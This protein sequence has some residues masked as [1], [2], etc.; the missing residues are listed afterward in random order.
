MKWIIPIGLLGA[1]VFISACGGS[2]N[3]RGTSDSSATVTNMDTTNK[4]S[5]NTNKGEQDFINYAVPA[6]EKEMIWLQAGIKGGRSKALKDHAKMMLRDHKKLDSTVHQYLS[7]HPALTAPSVDT[8]NTVDLTEKM[9]A[10]WDSAW[11]HKMVEDH[12]GL[13]EKLQNSQSE[14]KDTAL[15]A[16]VNNTIPVVQS[17]LAMAK[18]LQTKIK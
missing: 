12:S 9:G 5:Q 11:A 17:H 13:L 14:V 6:N 7:S 4:I 2:D 16:I 18:S 1:G 8:V 10:G 15:L 3:S